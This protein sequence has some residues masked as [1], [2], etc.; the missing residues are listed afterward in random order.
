ML[1][2]ITILEFIIRRFSEFRA[3]NILIFSIRKV[4]NNF[5]PRW[6]PYL[7]EKYYLISLENLLRINS[8]ENCTRNLYL[9][10]KKKK[11]KINDT[12]T[13]SRGLNVHYIPHTDDSKE[14]EEYIYMNKRDR[15][16]PSIK[17]R[18][19]IE[20]LLNKISVPIGGIGNRNCE[21][22]ARVA[23]VYN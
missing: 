4:N 8:F 17:F 16:K 12:F 3:R 7:I 20:P 18:R 11:L 23:A 9:R 10:F 15:M 1:G 19:D 14:F 21:S 6:T 5:L 22:A 2:K 13:I